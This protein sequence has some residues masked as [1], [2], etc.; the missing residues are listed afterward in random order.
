MHSACSAPTTSLCIGFAAGDV[1]QVAQLP[2]LSNSEVAV[3]L[4]QIR[5]LMSERD[6]LQAQVQSLCLAM[7]LLKRRI[8]AAKAERID[9][10]QLELEF[11]ELRQKLEALSQ[12][13]PNESNENAAS[14]PS[15]P[16]RPKKKRSPIGRRNLLLSAL[17][18]E[19]VEIRDPELEALGVKPMGFEV[20]KRLGYRTGGAICIVISRAKYAVREAEG[21]IVT[22][23][24]PKE[25]VARP[26]CA[27][28]MMAK[29]IVDKFADGLPFNRQSER[30][31][32]EGL[33]LDRSVMCRMTEDVGMTLGCIV[34]AARDHA[35][36]HAFCLSTDATGV[37]IQPTRIK[38]GPRQQC[39]RGHF[40]VTIADADHVFFSYEPKHTSKAVYA[41]FAG[42]TGYIQADASS[43]YDLLFQTSKTRVDS[44]GNEIVPP[45]EV[46]CMSHARRKMFE[47]AV[48]TKDARAREG[49]MR[50]RMLFEKEAEWGELTPAK[51][52]ILRN[53]ILKPW[54]DDFFEWAKT[55]Y[56][57]IKGVRGPLAAA[58]GYLVRHEWPLRRFLEDGRLKIDNN[59]SERMLRSVAVGRKNWLF[60]GSDD[61]AEAAAN[62]MS[63]V[64]S[65]KLHGINPVGYLEAVIRLVPVWP[66]GR[67][68]ELA[69]MN[70][71]ATRATLVQA[72]LDAP[73]GRMTVPAPKQ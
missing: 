51:R 33:A 49:L 57:S 36:Q 52:F 44:A 38:G 48:S 35:M 41:L 56:S 66:A 68:L 40:F 34:L 18:Q 65:C 64:A 17:P 15:G 59:I 16:V 69:P 43:V 70:W 37:A 61:H 29:I 71:L 14:P 27:A 54:L 24:L 55:I 53:Q 25:I 12:P 19:C 32:R 26:L 1:A 46:G 45:D 2:E 5:A 60:F 6:K 62:L 30:F 9:T 50:I 13:V 8:F 72:E 42:Y 3:L 28:S 10:A 67:M 11:A 20:S 31:A 7:D 47:A 22:A 4:E 63:L 73:F 23:A 58:F 21:A 39:Q